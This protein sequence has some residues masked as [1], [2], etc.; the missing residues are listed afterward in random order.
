MQEFKIEILIDEDGNVRA[1]TKGMEGEVCVEELEEVLKGLEGE[2]TYK[3]K[4]E[5]Y[6]SKQKMTQKLVLKNRR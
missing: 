2:L 3:N 6:K 1:E 5:F 4:P